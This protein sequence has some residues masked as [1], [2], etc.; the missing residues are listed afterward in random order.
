MYVCMHVRTYTTV[1]VLFVRVAG[2]T[3]VCV[4]FWARGTVRR[5]RHRAVAVRAALVQGRRRTSRALVPHSP[6]CRPTGF[7]RHC[8]PP[9]VVT[10]VQTD[11]LSCCRDTVLRRSLCQ[12][13]LREDVVAR[14]RNSNL[15]AESTLL[16]HPRVKEQDKSP[17][18]HAH[19]TLHL[20]VWSGSN[21][22]H[23]HPHEPC[24]RLVVK[25]RDHHEHCKATLGLIV[26]PPFTP[27]RK[28]LK[29]LR[30]IWHGCHPHQD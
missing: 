16:S 12:R 6:G 20:H 1:C 24:L 25:D 29:R 14:V 23:S 10:S 3:C 13:S 9:A 19:L 5:H 11:T 28:C 27:I 18:S 22:S 2:G 4:C 30:D 15:C 21:S 7:P 26:P 8:S 17:L